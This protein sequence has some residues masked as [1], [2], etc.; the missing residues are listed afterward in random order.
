MKLKNLRKIIEEIIFTGIF[1]FAMTGVA[2]G[3]LLNRLT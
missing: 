2:G 1:F 3:Y